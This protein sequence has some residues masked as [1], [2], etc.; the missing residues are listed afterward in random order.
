MLSQLF[1]AIL[2]KL[3]HH[4]RGSLHFGEQ[5]AAIGRDGY[6][7]RDTVLVG[8]DKLD[9]IVALLLKFLDS[10]RLY[11]LLRHPTYK[12]RMSLRK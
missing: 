6:E 12:V 3:G 5:D 4:T 10:S 7:V 11:L 8:L 2:L 1:H 9:D